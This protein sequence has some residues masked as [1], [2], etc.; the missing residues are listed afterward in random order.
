MKILPLS[1]RLVAYL[2]RC[3]LSGRFEKQRRLFEQNPFHPSLH[4]EILE[5]RRFRVCSFRITR[6]YRAVFVYLGR[7]AVEII[8]INAHYQ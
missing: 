1:K 3:G 5:P 4:T 2:V 6:T 7:D 8:D